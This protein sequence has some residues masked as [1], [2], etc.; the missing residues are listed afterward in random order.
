M[1]W[2]PPFSYQLAREGWSTTSGRC[3]SVTL[4]R[5]NATIVIT[6]VPANVCIEPYLKKDAQIRP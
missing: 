3:V 5:E 6:H 1:L 4:K 2:S